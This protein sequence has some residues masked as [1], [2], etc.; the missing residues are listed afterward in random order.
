MFEH[1]ERD[2]RLVMRASVVRGILLDR[3]FQRLTVTYQELGEMMRTLPGG[4]EL[5]QALAIITADDAQMNRPLSVAIVVNSR[6]GTPGQGFFNQ[7]RQLGLLKGSPPAENQRPKV[8]KAVLRDAF[9]VEPEEEAQYSGNLKKV[10]DQPYLYGY[11]DARY[12]GPLSDLERDFWLQ[13]ISSLGVTVERYWD[14]DVQ[15]Q[16]GSA[17]PLEAELPPNLW[18]DEM[19]PY[20]KLPPT[21]GPKLSDPTFRINRQLANPPTGHSHVPATNSRE[22]LAKSKRVRIPAYML[23]VGDTVVLENKREVVVRDVRIDPLRAALMR[24]ATEEERYVHWWT[25]GSTQ[26]REQLMDGLRILTPPNILERVEEARNK[27]NVLYGIQQAAAAPSS[28][29]L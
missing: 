9:E 19:G 17:S 6:T 29:E 4:G 8:S 22:V 16:L 26:Y 11:R 3:C 25:D 10:L 2:A 27:L 12:Q 14:L 21:A 20:L 15:A 7:C 28:S 13:Q 5:A 24:S 1:F 18:N 23:R